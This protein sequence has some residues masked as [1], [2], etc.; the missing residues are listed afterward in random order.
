MVSLEYNNMPNNIDSDILRGKD[1][2]IKIEQYKCEI[3][4]LTNK[5]EKEMG[6]LK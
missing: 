1:C 4:E 6:K 3:T 5:Y 2:H